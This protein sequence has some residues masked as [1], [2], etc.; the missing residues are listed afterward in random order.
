MASS[1][2]Q[3]TEAGVAESEVADPCAEC[4]GG[5]CSFKNLNIGYHTLD[6]GERYDSSLLDLIEDGH[7]AESLLFDDGTVPDM[8][9][10]VMDLRHLGGNRALV[11][12]CGHLD[13]G[14]CTEYDRRPGMCR[15]FE[16]DALEGEMT[17]DEFKDEHEVLPPMRDEANLKRVTERVHEILGRLDP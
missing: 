16:C 1:A 5:C 10:F 3:E 14:L 7:L 13:G 15:N 6:D 11:F 12:D 17:V 9:W 4:A 2:R 8:E